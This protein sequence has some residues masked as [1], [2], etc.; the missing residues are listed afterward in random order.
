MR[1]FLLTGMYTFKVTSFRTSQMAS[2]EKPLLRV[3]Y[4]IKYVYHIQMSTG[5][6][7]YRYRLCYLYLKDVVLMQEKR[8]LSSSSV[9]L[10]YKI[11]RTKLNAAL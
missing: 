5:T 4:T 7:G 9:R 3:R 2:L 8:M 11:D 10:V 6:E 1:R